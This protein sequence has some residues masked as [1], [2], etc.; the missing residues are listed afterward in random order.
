MLM[1]KLWLIPPLF[2]IMTLA[3][4]GRAGADHRLPPAPTLFLPHM[5]NVM[6]KYHDQH[7]KYSREWRLLDFEYS[8]KRPKKLSRNRS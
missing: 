4:Q 6:Q 8:N 5:V 1:S 3:T 7:G 2:C